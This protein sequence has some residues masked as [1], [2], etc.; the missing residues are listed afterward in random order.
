M[1][2]YGRGS[3]PEP[4]HPEDP[5]HGDSGW[6]GHEAQQGR[7][8]FGGVPQHQYP[9]EPQHQQYLQQEQYPGQTQGYPQQP[10]PH[11]Q[12][13]VQQ[14][15]YD[16]GGQAWDTAHGGYAGAPQAA[17]AYPG[18]GQY[19]G[20]AEGYPAADG[21][22]QADP[23]PAPDPYAGADPYAQQ[24]VGGYPGEAP[25]LYGT[26][27]AYPPPKPPGRR[28]PEPGAE[29]EDDEPDEDSALSD[30]GRD[31]DDN[32]RDAG[33]G[34]GRR[35]GRSKGKG[36]GKPKRSGAACLVAALVIAGVVGGGGYYG[37][38][39]LKARFGSAEDYAGSGNGESVE[40]EIPNG[41]TV[42]QMGSILKEAGVVAST[43][44][45]VDAA[46]ADK[47]ST[48]IQPG[49]YT[50]QKKMSSASAIAVLVDPSKLNVLTIPEGKRAVDVYKM[51]DKKLGKPE[52]TTA[53]IAQQQAKNLGLPAWAVS[54]RKVR[55]PLE[56]FLYP[57]RYDL[58][59]ES[60]PES[61]LKQMVK[62][63]NDKYA[64]LGLEGKAKELGLANPY[65]LVI[66]ASLV[67][68]EGNKH[69]DFRKMSEVIYNRLKPSN[70][71]TNQK[72]EFDS[73]INYI[74]GTS[75]INVSR[76]ETRRID[77]PYNTYRYAGLPPGPISNPGDE[78]VNAALDPDKG[79]W[80]F[81]V[82]IDGNTTTF[83]KTF[84]EH[85][86]LVAEFNERQKKKSGG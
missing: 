46:T 51:I 69:D 5:L 34:G 55:D 76:E 41:A 19:P 49:T 81:F 75:N 68:V 44:A 11:Q 9:Q 58:S 23:Y 10:Q 67:Q 60:T 35:A 12:M 7:M 31:G 29:P 28:D 66:V 62:N 20:A 65:E 79:G 17:Q 27:E 15:A 70:T 45:F 73:T 52:G 38:S 83:T 64:A 82:S 78:A 3:G 43:Q 33:S 30:S 50:L 8:P 1:T 77:D 36:K 40:V 86:K 61:L 84:A 85:D 53:Q 63:A 80:M 2:E 42:A 59:K 57:T 54:T 25:D 16:G 21:Y 32:D 72:I 26:P 14:P 37:Y 18:T 22:P 6:S 39:Y 4:W 56:G 13:P 47:R 48:G 24:P 71:A 74:K